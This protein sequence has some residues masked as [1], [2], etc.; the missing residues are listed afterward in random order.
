M[1]RTRA[2]FKLALR[3]CRRTEAQHRADALASSL[4]KGGQ[5]GFWSALRSQNGPRS[6]LPCNI[7][8]HSGPSAIASM[9][10]QHYDS[11]LNSVGSIDRK[12][13]VDDTINADVSY[14]PGMSAPVSE[15]GAAINRLA[16]GKS[17]DADGLSAE[18]LK[19]AGPRLTV[20]LSLLFSA[21]LVHSHVSSTLLKVI[22][23][24]II[25]KQNL[26]PSLK[27]NYRPIAISSQIYKLFE[28][29]LLNRLEM[30]LTFPGNQFGLQ[31]HQ[32]HHVYF[33]S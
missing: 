31:T 21:M 14:D 29:L 15:V 25:K 20:L 30:H 19:Y 26:N 1:R 5:A 4:R 3:E 24:P 11:L 12:S 16:N 32:T 8:G 9:C 2:K 17:C 27:N 23:I 33:C 10:R 28:S 6:N 13:S 22:L 18:H 7:D